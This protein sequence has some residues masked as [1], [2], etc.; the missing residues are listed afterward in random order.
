VAALTAEIE[1]LLLPLGARP[2]WEKII[3]ARAADLAPL[4]P[5]LPA[6][7]DLARSYDPNGKFRS[8]YLD[9]HVLG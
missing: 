1:E 7:R 8:E 4:Y 9:T 3:H 6:F 5:K 2:H